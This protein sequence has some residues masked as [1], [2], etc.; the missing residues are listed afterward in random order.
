MAPI[1]M[2]R[3]TEECVNFYRA[4][5]EELQSLA[6]SGSA[7]VSGEGVRIYWEG[8]PIWGRLR[9]LSD[10]FAAGRAAIVASTYCNS[11][12][13]DDFDPDRPLESLA[14]AY[15]QIFINRGERSKLEYLKRMIADYEVDGIVFHDA[16]TCFNNSNNRFGLPQRL[17]EE[18]G[19]ATL[20]L[21]GDLNDL[22]FFP[23]ERARTKVETFIEQLS[24]R[25]N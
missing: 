8:M 4:A 12:V 10:V 2:L 21:D 7:A 14:Y 13:F 18:T 22:R 1:V 3:G 5:Y 15:T 20:T 9:A 19:I 16:A 11:W 25:V 17:Q 24:T 6:E 23:E